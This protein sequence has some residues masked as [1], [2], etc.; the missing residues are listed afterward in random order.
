MMPINGQWK[1]K[2]V[3]LCS[4]DGGGFDAV[5]GCGGWVREMREK[6]EWWWESVKKSSV[7]NLLLD[8]VLQLI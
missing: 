4:F 6:R 1:K 7:D 5:C 8:Y 3:Y 2:K